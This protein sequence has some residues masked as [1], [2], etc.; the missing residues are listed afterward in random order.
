MAR[1]PQIPQPEL[2]GR[3]GGNMSERSVMPDIRAT[4]A[5][6]EDAAKLTAHVGDHYERLQLQRDAAQE[7]LQK[8]VDGVTATR[9]AG[10][11]AE[12][13]NNLF[14]QLRQQFNDTP[15]KLPE[16]Y[17]R[18]LR[19][20]TDAEIKAAPSQNV[21]LDIS[22]KYAVQ[23]NQHTAAVHSWMI[24][25]MTQKAKSDLVA[26]SNSQIR[27]AQ[28]QTT[29][30]GLQATVDSALATLGPHIQQLHGDPDAVRQ[31]LKTDMASAWVEANGPDNP[32]GVALAL[33]GAKKGGPLAELKPVQLEHYQKQAQAWVK[34]YGERER[35][36]VS[37]EAVALNNKLGDLF[38][39]GQ[40]D[41][42]NAFQM[43]A[44][45][46]AKLDAIDKNPQYKDNPAEKAA[47]TKIVQMQLDG[48]KYLREAAEK[49][50]H[51]DPVFDAPKVNAIL[52]RFDELGKPGAK[53]PKDLLKI[54]E[55][56][57][58][59]AHAQADRWIPPGYASTMIK[60]LAQMT[61]KG[62]DRES[63]NTGW[64]VSFLGFGGRSPQ[65]AG[66]VVLNNYFKGDNKA[67]GKL[68]L[69]QQNQ[70]RVDYLGQVV[71]AQETGRN[72]DTKAAEQMA[73]ASIKNVAGR[74]GAAH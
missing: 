1:M 66:N 30:Q 41:S 20:M 10:D 13:A 31:K 46:E 57:K 26:M 51:F 4:E 6:L 70:A 61:G 39:N 7:K 43:K 72:L 42:K 3:P 44:S 67:F 48:L 65:Q 55:L 52:D 38:L 23:D 59:L 45:L 32:A 11:H 21:A 36:Q 5:P 50:G 16:E 24:L 49:P 54:V 15:E 68:T 69:E 64:G 63:K 71:D 18:Q 8:A 60:S 53:G 58:D 56:Q 25:R 9:M 14:E 40:L 28:S 74:Q 33:D 73:F 47:Q 2:A 12:K 62:I 17:R 27:A 34:G 35:F 37:K 29:V 22:Q 19:E